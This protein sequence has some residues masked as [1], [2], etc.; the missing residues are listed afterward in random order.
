MSL[1]NRVVIIT[2]ANGATGRLAAL[3]FAEAGARL[4]LV[5]RNLE[6][7]QVMAEQLNLAENRILLQAA[8]LVDPQAARN[9]AETVKQKFGGAD[10]LLHLVG[11]WTGGKTVAEFD[12]SETEEMLAQHLWT[13]WHM[14]QAFTPLMAEN[15][16]GRIIAISSPLARHPTPKSAPYAIA[17][18]AQETLLMTLAQELR[19]SGVTANVLQVRTIDVQHER[20]SQPTKQNASWTTPEEIVA[21]VLYLCSDQ[22]QAVTGARLPLYGGA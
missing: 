4:A 18:S 17:K 7:L 20:E 5:S 12:S 15:G 3:K 11:G 13:T 6:H 1:E 22:A 14:A 16:W 19:G 2:G 10:V 8:D 9:L 21:A